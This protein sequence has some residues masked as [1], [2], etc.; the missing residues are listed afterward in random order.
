M[1]DA[2]PGID[3]TKITLQQLN[4]PMLAAQHLRADV[5][6]TDLVHP[7]IS[8][9]KWFKLKY[10][11]AEA[12]ASNAKGIITF[13]GAYSNHLLATACACYLNNMPV[14][15]IIRGEEPA[16]PS[17]TLQQLH[18]FNMRLRF[19]SRD[20]YKNK[21][22]LKKDLHNE[23]PGYYWVNEGGQSEL[24]V[25]GAAEM[26][27][28][29]PLSE[30]THILC[31]AGTGTMMKGLINASLPSQKVIG[32]PVLKINDHSN[33]DLL[34]FLQSNNTRDN[35]EL[36]YE[37]HEG[38]YAQKNAALTGFMN[39]LFAAEKVPTDF[40]YTGKLFRGVYQLIEQNYFPPGSRLLLIHSGGL[41]GNRSL[42]PGTLIF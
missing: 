28:L 41:Q 42:P 17:P 13:G 24:G 29:V 4:S 21:V 15:G 33:N 34:T 12:N 14:A 8:G 30:Y 22:Q 2:L 27:Q 23:F 10:H 40:V 6:R 7:V 37:F 9:N 31:A 1:N 20:A 38:G 5:L 18:G 11:L 3:I 39:H 36:K 25:R 35:Y 19:V 26:L 32:I 16:N